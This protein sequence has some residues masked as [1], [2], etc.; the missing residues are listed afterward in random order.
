MSINDFH[1][2]KKLK[3][4]TSEREIPI[5]NELKKLFIELVEDKSDDETLFELPYSK[6]NGYV[7][8][9]SKFFFDLIK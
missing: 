2:D 6:H 8:K 4:S 3:N 9:P 5:T 7:G 1:S